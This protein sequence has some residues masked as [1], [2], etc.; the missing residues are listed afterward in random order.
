M[1]SSSDGSTSQ[2]IASAHQSARGCGSA[3]SI[4]TWNAYAMAGTIDA[5]PDKKP[6]DVGE[7]DGGVGQLRAVD[8]A[9][10][11][12]QV[13][14]RVGD[15]PDVDVHPGQHPAAAQPE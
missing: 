9:A 13:L 10:G 15:V 6:S 4:T 11:A 5:G 12:D 1:N 7:R 2:P 3:A 8:R 14:D